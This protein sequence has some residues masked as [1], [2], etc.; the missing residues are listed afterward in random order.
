MGLSV[1]ASSCNGPNRTNKTV[2]NYDDLI[3]L[4]YSRTAVARN[5][6][7]F[8]TPSQFTAFDAAIFKVQCSMFLTKPRFLKVDV[9]A[10]SFC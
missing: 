1:L 4:I 7:D 6:L 5:E 3:M 10:I 2:L 9:F 8:L